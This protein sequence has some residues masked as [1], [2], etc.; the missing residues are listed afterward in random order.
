MSGNKDHC[1]Y[2]N[3]LSLNVTARVGEDRVAK[4][5]KLNVITACLLVSGSL[6]Y[7]TLM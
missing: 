1:L 2:Q 7:S 6:L 5:I 4:G 3:K